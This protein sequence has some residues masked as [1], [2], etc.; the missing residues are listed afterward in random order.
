M[1]LSMRVPGGE[2]WPALREQDEKRRK[3]EERK[4][5]LV[6]IESELASLQKEEDALNAPPPAEGEA[7]V[8]E[9]AA[10]AP[11]KKTQEEIAARRE[12]LAG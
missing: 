9:P 2:F 8:E 4:E 10:D 11:P 1:F 5:S 6:K 12:E 3:S 7:P